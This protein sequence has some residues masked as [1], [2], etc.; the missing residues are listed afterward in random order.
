MQRFVAFS[1]V[2]PSERFVYGRATDETPDVD[3]DVVDYEATRR[4]VADWAE[5]RNV[6]EMH[7]ERAVGVAEEIE[8]DDT[9]KALAIGVRVVDDAAW[10]K[11]KAGVYKGFSIGGQVRTRRRE[12]DYSRITEY[13]LAEISLVDRPANPAAKFTLVKREGVPMDEE[14]RAEEVAAEEQAAEE[15]VAKEETPLDREAVTEIV[16]VQLM[17][18]LTELGLI[19]PEGG[20]PESEAELALAAKVTELRKALRKFETEQ[21]TT[22]AKRAGDLKKLAGDLAQVV[23][24]VEDFDERLTKAE[25]LA[26]G[27]GPVL[28]EL[29]SLDSGAG[30]TQATLKAVIDESDDP[31]TKQYLGQ[32]LAEMQIRAIHQR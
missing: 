28:R 26:A 12:G 21:T 6:R 15:E 10:A 29:G 23:A 31:L 8:L 16:R 32:K 4:A 2:D 22:L 14:E 19:D 24:A 17:G 25:T 13:Q 30:L 11:V 27:A 20:K 3:G 7:G 5:W 9:A 18:L 1:K